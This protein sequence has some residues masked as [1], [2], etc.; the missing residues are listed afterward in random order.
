MKIYRFTTLRRGQH[1]VSFHDG[2]KIHK[3]GSPF[4]DMAVFRNAKKADDFIKELKAEGYCEEGHAPAEVPTPPQKLAAPK[5]AQQLRA[6]L[7]TLAS[8]GIAGEAD[9]ARRKLARLE[10][11]Y[12]W[13]APVEPEKGDIFAGLDFDLGYSDSARLLIDFPVAESDIASFVQWALS[14]AAKVQGSLRDAPGWRVAV[15][16]EAPAMAMP[17]LKEVAET[18][19]AAFRDLWARFSSTPGVQPAARKV[20]FQGLWDGMLDD[21][22]KAGQ[23]LPA[24]V[25]PV[26]KASR[27]KRKLAVAPGVAVHPYS[28]ALDLGR[29][30]RF[31]IP[32]SE[33]I[34]SLPSRIEALAA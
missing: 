1:T 9:S 30:I 33:I 34:E 5:A 3:D 21:Q 7:Y 13:S 8:R 4:F 10:T 18:I 26:V 11:R 22:R 19:S 2:V 32:T 29:C 31:S 15:W 17:K 28:L 14:K 20:F 23:S 6:K 27:A 25:A 24:I 12:D 16:I